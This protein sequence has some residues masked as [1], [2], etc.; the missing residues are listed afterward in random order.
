[1]TTDRFGNEFAAGLPY[2]RGAIVRSTEDDFVKLE[3]ARR[4]IERRIATHGP[5]SIFNFSG[6]ER[7]MPLEASEIALADDEVAPAL[8]GERLRTL[9]LEHL[10]GDAGR[11]DVMLFNRL[12]R[13]RPSPRTWPSSPRVTP[14]SDSRRPTPIQ[15]RSARRGNA[16]RVLWRPATSPGSRRRSTARRV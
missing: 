5:E 8:T 4:V 13:R 16:G 15:P 6:L 9:S 12:G 1:V 14:C 10:G 7:G 11:H 3:R 2:A